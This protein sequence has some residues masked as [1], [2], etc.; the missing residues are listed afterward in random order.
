MAGC[1]SKGS[2]TGK[3]TVSPAVDSADLACREEAQVRLL[4]LGPRFG[5]PRSSRR[6]PSFAPPALRRQFEHA[7]YAST[8]K[9]HLLALR[10]R[11]VVRGCSRFQSVNWILTSTCLPLFT[12]TAAVVELSSIYFRGMEKA[13]FPLWT[14]PVPPPHMPFL[15]FVILFC[16]PPCTTLGILGSVGGATIT[17]YSP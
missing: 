4:E 7:A 1:G 3:V 9:R 5:V 16:S 8:V 12:V 15:S 6:C 17:L 2:L 10:A 14:G 11:E 13:F